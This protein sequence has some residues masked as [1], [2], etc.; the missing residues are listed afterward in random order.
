[1]LFQRNYFFLGPKSGCHVHIPARATF[2][3]FWKTPLDNV[4]PTRHSSTHPPQ[5]SE[6]FLT[7]GKGEHHCHLS[8]KV[9]RLQS[10]HLPAV[11]R[12]LH[13]CVV[14]IPEFLLETRKGSGWKESW[15]SSAEPPGS[16]FQG[17]SRCSSWR[18]THVVSLPDLGAS[19]IVHLN[20]AGISLEMTSCGAG[21]VDVTLYK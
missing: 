17:C 21:G 14:V 5:K 6:M 4:G 13:L 10:S 12:S 8:L 11:N 1:M 7:Q 20:I 3:L 16:A 9:I 19:K 2:F 15:A 18:L